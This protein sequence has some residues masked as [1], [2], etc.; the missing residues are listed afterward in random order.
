MQVVRIFNT[1]FD[2]DGSGASRPTF[3]GGKFY[4]Q[5]PA[6][7]RQ[8]ELGNGELVDAPADPEK[9]AVKAEQAQAAA[10][11]AVAK[12]ESAAD[13]AQAAAAAAEAAAQSVEP[14]APQA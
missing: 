13:A 2:V 8:V 11:A 4:P 3:E 6:S 9:A 14:D 7:L 1:H 5:T 12:A 10:D